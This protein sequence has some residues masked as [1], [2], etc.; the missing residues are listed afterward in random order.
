MHKMK[1]LIFSDSHGNVSNMIAAVKRQ[2]PNLVIHLGDCWQDGERLRMVFPRLPVEQVN[3]NC[4]FCPKGVWEKC[5]SFGGKTAFI[6][7]GHTYGVKSGYEAAVEAANG[8]GADF[9]LFGHTH[10]A[11]LEQV[12]PL[13]VMNPGSVGDPLGGSYGMISVDS[14]GGVQAQILPNEREDDAS[15]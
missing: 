2:A 3:G 12:G 10:M 6:C 15:C 8:V 5:V 9:L 7:H 11:R 4:D 14:D 1:A 13:L